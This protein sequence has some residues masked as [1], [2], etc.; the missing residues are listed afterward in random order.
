MALTTR[1]EP[2]PPSAPPSR[3]TLALPAARRMRRRARHRPRPLWRAHAHNDYEHPR[4][5]LDALDHRFGSVEADIFLVGD[6]LLVAHDPADLDPTR[7]LES[8][9]LDP[10]A[11]RVKA[12]HGSRVPGLPPA[13]P[14]ARRHQDRGLRR[15]TSNSTAI[16]GATGTCSRTYAHGQVRPGAVTAVISGDRAARVPMEAQTRPPGL[17]RR[18][19]RRPRHRGAR[20]LHPADQRQLD[21]QLHLAGRRR[22]PRRRAAEAARHRRHGPRARAAGAV[23]GHARRW[24]APPGTRCGASCSPPASTTSTPTTWPAWRPSWTPTDDGRL[25]DTS[26]GHHSFGGHVSRPDEPSATP[27]LRPNAAKRTAAWRRRLTM[28]ISISVVVLLL[29][30]AVIFLRNGGLKVSHALVCAA[31]RVLLA[32]TSIAPTIHSGL[33]ATADIV[34]QPQTVSLRPSVGEDPDAVRHGP[35]GARRTGWLRTVTWA[36]ARH[37]GGQGRGAAAVQAEGVDR[38]QRPHGGGDFG[39]RQPA[40]VR[41][42]RRPARAATAAVRRPRHPRPYAR[43]RPSSSRPGSGRPPSSTG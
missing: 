3:R 25:R 30:L 7:T 28:A 41:R 13:A 37:P 11:A 4:P 31:A 16:C 10:L 19:P 29:I 14:T 2:S 40:A 5:L 18:P 23:L 38:A 35:L 42:A 26:A 6:Q 1:A 43:P 21:A 27:H 36:R 17:L 22:L 20:L 8:L 24:R 9:Y 39:D 34:E 12:N 15:P 32:G 33:T